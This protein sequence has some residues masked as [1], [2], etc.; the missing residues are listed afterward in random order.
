MDTPDMYGQE[1]TEVLVIDL[2]LA[3]GQGEAWKRP[4]WVVYMWSAVEI[5][6]VSN[7]WQVSSKLRAK[8]LRL[9]GARIGEHVILRPRMKVKFPWNLEIGD[10]SWIGEGVWI[11]NRDRVCI[12]SDVAISQETL[13]TTG[14][15]NF[16]GD[17]GVITKAIIVEDGAWI[18]SRCVL[19]GGVKIGRSA[20][21]QPLTRVS[22]DVPENSIYGSERPS[23]QGKR[24]TANPEKD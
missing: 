9:F 12:G 17:M 21:I 23:V 14:S 11:H 8:T 5:L 2:S 7:R 4:K 10:R 20:V 6:V 3:P 16:R 19:T 15:H 18:T 22:E 24:F 1:N 13:I